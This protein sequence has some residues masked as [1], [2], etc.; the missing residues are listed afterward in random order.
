VLGVWIAVQGFGCGLCI[1]AVLGI[2]SLL[3]QLSSSGLSERRHKAASSSPFERH[4]R[5][6][7]LWNVGVCSAIVWPWAYSCWRRTHTVEMPIDCGMSLCWWF[8]Q[9]NCMKWTVVVLKWIVLVL[10]WS[11][12]EVFARD[13]GEVTQKLCVGELKWSGTKLFT[14]DWS[15]NLLQNLLFL[16]WYWSGQFVRK[17]SWICVEVSSLPVEIYTEQPLI[18]WGFLVRISG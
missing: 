9:C 5:W 13:C 11:E 12:S 18:F 8:S 7:I 17:W 4:W 10:K 1:V 15:F 14:R 2:C 6:L 16:C 3:C